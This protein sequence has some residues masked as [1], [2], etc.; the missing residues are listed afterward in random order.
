M[1]AACVKYAWLLP[2]MLAEASDPV[3]EAYWREVEP[4]LKYAA[5]GKG[6]VRMVN[7]CDEAL[8]LADQL[9]R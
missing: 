9:G 8:R 5:R 7:W 3:A 4:T 1:T 2:Q 6:M